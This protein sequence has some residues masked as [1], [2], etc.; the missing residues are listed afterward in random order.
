MCF[1]LLHNWGI[2]GGFDTAHIAAR[3]V[4]VI[5]RLLLY[6][7]GILVIAIKFNL[8]DYFLLY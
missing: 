5:V 3:L 6:I 7:F 1:C 4:S 8:G 2:P